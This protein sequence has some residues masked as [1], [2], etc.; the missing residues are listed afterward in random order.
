MP[1]KTLKVEH[2]GPITVEG[3]DD[4]LAALQAINTTLLGEIT[5]APNAAWAALFET[6]VVAALA[7]QAI[8]ID[9]TTPVN[10]AIDT[11]AGPVDITGTV[12]VDGTVSVDNFP[13]TTAISNFADLA[14]V[15][16]TVTL[17]GEVV[18]VT[19]DAAFI[20]EMDDIADAITNTIRV[21]YEQTGMCVYDAA[22]DP[23]DPPVKQYTERRY[24]NVGV[25]L[26]NDVVLSQFNA[27]GTVT[28]YTLAAGDL[29]AACKS[30]DSLLQNIVTLLSDVIGDAT[31][32]CPC[33]EVA[34]VA[35]AFPIPATSFITNTKFSLDDPTQTNAYGDVGND[36][37]TAEQL[38]AALNA[39]SASAVP[40]TIPSGIDYSTTVWDFGNNG[41]DDYVFVASGP[42]PTSLDLVSQSVSIPVTTV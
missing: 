37:W 41:T 31:D 33:D 19:P 16:L 3:Q 26:S 25:F 10:V 2:C 12:T 39:Q 4:I 17:D 8:T 23:I 14:G 29:V 20:Q 6:A 11:S 27:D 32:N 42:V 22:G 5:V 40:P 38:A 15:E 13:A 18:T 30:D 28:G 34:P 9:S 24:S 7:A 36:N 35:A 1:C 21:D